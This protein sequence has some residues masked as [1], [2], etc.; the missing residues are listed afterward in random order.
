MIK[1]IIRAVWKLARFLILAM[2]DMQLSREEST[3]RV[4]ELNTSVIGNVHNTSP[5]AEE[6]EGK[7][8][9]M[10]NMRCL[11]KISGI[12]SCSQR[13]RR[14]SSGSVVPVQL[15]DAVSDVPRRVATAG[16]KSK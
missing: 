11:I 3:R 4:G 9:P 15:T 2:M 5:I 8:R 7:K 13:A 10:T 12:P 1:H 6:E 14:V 16:E